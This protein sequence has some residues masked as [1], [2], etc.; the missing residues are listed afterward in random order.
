M[1]ASRWLRV[2]SCG[3]LFAGLGLVSIG[4]SS[5]VSPGEY[6][7]YRVAIDKS[8]VKS[9]GC[10]PDGKVPAA[11][12]AS[13]DDLRTSETWEIFAG[14]EEAEQFF[15]EIDGGKQ[16]LEGT[17][18]DKNYTFET[19]KV[20]VEYEKPDGTGFKYTKT[21]RITIDVTVDGKTISGTVT[22][23]HSEK[24]SGDKCPKV[25]ETCSETAEYVGTE[26]D[27]VEL[28]HDL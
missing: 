18:A 7:I 3:A 22:S 4:C 2:L 12:K 13:S 9:A 6:K 20:D 27:D 19:T 23:T 26:V 11:V 24:C 28:K 10:Y 1:A 5:A 15:L 25:P 21:D 17:F 8:G 14:S 16:T